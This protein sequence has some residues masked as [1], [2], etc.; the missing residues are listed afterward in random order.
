MTPLRASLLFQQGH[1]DPAA[2]R[3]WRL[4]L[5]ESAE[6]SNRS[7]QH[8]TLRL[9]EYARR[10]MLAQLDDAVIRQFSIQPR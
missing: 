10:H 6:Q 4:C 8:V 7:R 2:Q 5:G 1:P 9:A 3:C